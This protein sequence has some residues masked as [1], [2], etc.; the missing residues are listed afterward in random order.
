M[1]LQIDNR[2]N[3]DGQQRPKSPDISSGTADSA[4]RPP[5]GL[6]CREAPL[7]ITRLP[8]SLAGDLGLQAMHL[9]QQQMLE[10]LA[11]ARR[12]TLIQFAASEATQ[13]AQSS[14]SQARWY[15]AHKEQMFGLCD[16]L[17]VVAGS[18]E[19]EA[20]TLKFLQALPIPSALV[21]SE[22]QARQQAQ[23]WVQ[24]R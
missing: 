21:Q 6:D 7:L 13:D 9:W 20:V 17:I 4:A 15:K 2:Y 19:H 16:G 1:N 23:A 12:F 18:K 3:S 11:S 22:D 5:L 10:W 24:S 8:A 14:A